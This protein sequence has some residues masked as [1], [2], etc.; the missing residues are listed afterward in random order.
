MKAAV[1]LARPRNQS[2]TPNPILDD[3][4]STRR[5]EPDVVS[6]DNR[7]VGLLLCSAILPLTSKKVAFPVNENRKCM[8]EF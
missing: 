8:S 1:Q 3:A 5:T 4:L 6:I 7:S 2:G